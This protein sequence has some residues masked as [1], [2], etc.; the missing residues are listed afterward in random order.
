M[1][2][3]QEHRAVDG[4]LIQPNAVYGDGQLRL[5]LDIPSATI[6]R[7]R[8]EGRLRHVR[9]GHRIFY[10]GQ[11]ILDWLESSS[12]AATSEATNA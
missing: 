12:A 6:V 7:E 3:L 11:W 2:P 5:L 9:K 1:T 8:R 10:R 4:F